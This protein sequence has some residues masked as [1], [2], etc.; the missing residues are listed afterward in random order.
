MIELIADVEGGLVGGFE[1]F[2]TGVVRGATVGI[3][4]RFRMR[5]GEIGVGGGG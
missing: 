2:L 1:E 5:G 4:V 3:W